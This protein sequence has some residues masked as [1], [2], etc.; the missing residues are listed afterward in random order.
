M[1]ALVA[2]SVVRGSQQGESHG[3][4]YLIDLDREIVYQTVDWDT[5]DI[6]WQGRG[7]DRGLRGIEFYGD[8]VYV[9]ASDELFVYTPAFEQVTSVRSP[10]LKHCHEIARH[11]SQL[12]LTSTGFDSVLGFD[13][14]REVFNW[15]LSVSRM[16]RGFRGTPFDPR[17]T[18]GPA[19]PEPAASQQRCVHRPRHVPQRTP[20]QGNAAL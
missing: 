14:E 16:Q 6:D 13:L 1:T 2:T 20:N 3:G 18:G 15:G 9:A 5:A 7:W 8:R 10:Y 4:I 19:A 12:Y 11:G 17:R